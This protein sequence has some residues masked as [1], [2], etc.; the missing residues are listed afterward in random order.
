MRSTWTTRKAQCIPDSFTFADYIR[1]LDGQTDSFMCSFDVSSLFTNIPLDETIKIRT[2]ALY[3][4]LES[5]PCTP[6]EV[7]VKLVHSATSTAEFSFDNIIYRQIDGV[8]MG[9]PL[10]PALAK[11]FVGYWEEKLFSE[12]S[13]PAVYF[14]Y[15]DDT[16]AIFRND[17]G[18][19]EFL[20]RLNNLHSS[21]RFTFEEKNNSLFWLSMLNALKTNYETSVYRKPTFTGQ[22]L[23]WE[24]F[25]PMKR[26]LV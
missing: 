17:K 24:F 4:N 19:E 9:S 15:V 7:F 8:E 5:Q 22:Y 3:D 2:D 12:I 25:S 26:K 21:L 20:S 18:S 1:K 23:R 14:R 16:C 6:T 10:G 13:K 11:I